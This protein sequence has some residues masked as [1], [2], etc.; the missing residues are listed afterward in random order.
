MKAVFIV[1]IP[2]FGGFRGGKVGRRILLFCKKKQKTLIHLRARPHAEDLGLGHAGK[3]A[4]VF[5]LL[6]LQKKKNLT[7]RFLKPPT[8]P[9][10]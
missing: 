6:F 1:V 9:P 10:H 7:S 3:F 8:T 2:L 5:L 4:K